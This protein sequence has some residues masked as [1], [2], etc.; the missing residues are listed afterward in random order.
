MP[1]PRIATNSASASRARHEPSRPPGTVMTSDIGG[2][3]L[4]A[5]YSSKSA[6]VT[7]SIASGGGQRGCPAPATLLESGALR[8][9]P[10][11]DGSPPLLRRLY[12][13]TIRM[14][15]HPQALKVLA[16][17]SFSESSFFPVIPELM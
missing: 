17:V 10:D 8:Q 3:R 6:I 7:N 4:P 2:L 13:W 16:A 14:A 9:P 15:G 12:D 5:R 11:N 1:R